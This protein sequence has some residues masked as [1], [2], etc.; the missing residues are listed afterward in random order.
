[1]AIFKLTNQVLKTA[2]RVIAEADK[3]SRRRRMR[4]STSST[5]SSVKGRRF[6][7]G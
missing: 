5:L 1:M 6:S 7:I 2:A 3:R 4:C